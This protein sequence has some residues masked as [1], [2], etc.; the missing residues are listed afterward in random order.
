LVLATIS[1]RQQVRFV[2]CSTALYAALAVLPPALGQ[3]IDPQQAVPRIAPSYGL[4]ALDVG[5]ASRVPAT[6]DAYRR[7]YDQYLGGWREPPPPLQSAYTPPSPSTGAPMA[8]PVSSWAAQQNLPPL[9]DVQVAAKPTAQSAAPLPAQLPAAPKPAAAPPAAIQPAAADAGKA[10][11]SGASFMPTFTAPDPSGKAQASAP[12]KPPQTQTAQTAPPPAPAPSAAPQPAAAPP[13]AD[14]PNRLRYGAG[15]K[16]GVS[17][18]RFGVLAHNRRPIASKTESG[19]QVNMEARFASPGFLSILFEP[20]PTVGASINTA[21]DTSF[22]YGGLTWGGF[23]WKGLF[24]EGFFGMSVHDGWLDSHD[25]DPPRRLMGSRVVFREALE[26]GYRFLDVHS[27][28][29]MV[30]HYSNAGWI[31]K[32]NQGNDDFGLRYGYKF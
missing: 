25:P 12:A 4:G 26:F 29:F 28:S 32:R 19:A 22:L 23:V 13:P 15:S 7:P 6:P 24:V 31:A 9:Q 11:G 5:G 21:G 1:L 10:G 3:V 16:Y 18:L 14:D 27:L 17:E 8:P 2:A 30:D 20:R